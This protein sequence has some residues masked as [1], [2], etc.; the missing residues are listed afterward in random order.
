MNQDV[1]IPLKEEKNGK[2]W[3]AGVDH[4]SGHCLNHFRRWQASSDW[5]KHGKS[6]PKLQKCDREREDRCDLQRSR[7][8]LW[9]EVKRQ[10]A[11]HG[12]RLQ[13][14]ANQFAFFSLLLS[15]L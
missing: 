3:N 13:N 4:H 11:F 7:R 10:R 12:L 1:M 5:G 2:H 9:K 14:R 8:N 15:R 6:D